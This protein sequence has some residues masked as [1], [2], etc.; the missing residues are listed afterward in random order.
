MHGP[1]ESGT[2]LLP[3]REVLEILPAHGGQNRTKKTAMAT[4]LHMIPRVSE[5]LP[6]FHLQRSNMFQFWART[7]NTQ[8]QT[9]VV[10]RQDPN[11]GCTLA[12]CISFKRPVARC[13]CCARSQAPITAQKLATLGATLRALSRC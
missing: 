6:E 8:L 7:A 4:N 9:P 12:A 1:H 11:V 13:R 10:H 3:A 2:L 5:V